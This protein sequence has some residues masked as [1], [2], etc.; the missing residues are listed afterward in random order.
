MNT[1][2]VQM[3]TLLIVMRYEILNRKNGFVKVFK[4][5]DRL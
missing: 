4:N 1:E 5:L 3:N 2:L